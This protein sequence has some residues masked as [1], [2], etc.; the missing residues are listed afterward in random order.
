MKSFGGSLALAVVNYRKDDEPWLEVAC[1][2]NNIDA[3][4]GKLYDMPIA[5]RLDF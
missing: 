2:Q 1:S 3:A 5:A 4:T